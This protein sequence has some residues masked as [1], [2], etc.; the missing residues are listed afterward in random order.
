MRLHRLVIEGIPIELHELGPDD[1][2]PVV[3]L[4]GLL[5][6]P[7]Y[8]EGLAGALARDGRRVLMPDLFGHGCSGRLSPFTF[9]RA[10]DLLAA[11]VGRL[12]AEQPAVF[13]HSF[14]APLAV[15]WAARHPARSLVAASPVGVAPLGL[16]WTRRLVP[17]APA[18]AAA[19]RAVAP[20]AANTAAGRRF[21]FGW[22]VGMHRPQAVDPGLAGRLI[23]GAADA[24][25][26]L[27]DVL[28]ELELLGLERAAAAGAL[29]LADGLGR[30]RP[31]RPRQRRRSWPPSCTDEAPCCPDCGHMPM[32]EAPYAFRRLLAG[33]L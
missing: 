6:S 20:V 19:A 9:A 13:G 28:P 14:G 18:V 24:A 11:A 21:V 5:G 29:P 4:H 1:A 8:L 12:G 16:G 15:H 32:L 30:R 25:P 10:A 26:C 17:A 33:W 7:A 3:L 2:E 31:P 27:A 23:R 22:F